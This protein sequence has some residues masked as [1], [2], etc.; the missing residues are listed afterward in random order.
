MKNIR[1]SDVKQGGLGDCWLMASFT[2]MAGVEG[3]IRHNCAAYDTGMDSS[4]I[5]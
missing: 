5:P 3:G 1:A 4:V 2:A